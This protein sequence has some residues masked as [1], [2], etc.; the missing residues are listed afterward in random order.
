MNQK[1]TTLNVSYLHGPEQ[2][3]RLA[4]LCRT[5]RMGRYRIDLYDFGNCL[6]NGEIYVFGACASEG[7]SDRPA[8]SIVSIRCMLTLRTR[9]PISPTPTLLIFQHELGKVAVPSGLESDE[10]NNSAMFTTKALELIGEKLD[11]N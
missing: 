3:L 9:A 4:T 8:L 11:N 10:W 5:E 7:N 6:I 1:T 2:Y